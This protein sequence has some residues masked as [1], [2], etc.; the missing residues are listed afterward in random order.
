MFNYINK[1][2]RRMKKGFFL[3]LFFFLAFPFLADAFNFAGNITGPAKLVLNQVEAF[4]GPIAS[5]FALVIIF[6]ILS[7][8]AFYVT[9]ILLQGAIENSNEALNIIHG[10]A[11]FV[12]QAGWNF[13]SG[14][15]NMI[16]LIAFIVIAIAI[17]LGSDSYG[18]KKSLPRLIIVAFLTN[19]TLL[20]VSMAVD[21]TNAI[22]NTVAGDFDQEGG[23]FLIEGITPL[24]NVIPTTIGILLGSFTARLIGALVPLGGIVANTALVLSFTALLPFLLQGAILG[25]ILLLLAGT[26]FLFYAV[27]TARTLVISILAILSPFAL[28]CYIFPGTKKYFDMWVQ[29]FIQWLLVGVALVFFLYIA[30]AMAPLAIRVG[31]DTIPLPSWMSWWT[32]ELVSYI[33]LLIYFIVVLGFTKKFVPALANSMID[34]AKGAAKVVAPYAQMTG[35]SLIKH[36][37]K[38]I[39][40]HASQRMQDNAFRERM[41]NDLFTPADPNAGYLSRIARN[42]RRARAKIYTEAPR[43]DAEETVKE[44]EE[45]FEDRTPADVRDA[46]TSENAQNEPEEVLGAIKYARKNKINIRRSL[47]SLSADEYNNVRR[48]ASLT[49]DDKDLDRMMPGHA[50]ERINNEAD[51]PAAAQRNI[52]SFVSGLSKDDAKNIG[53]SFASTL[54]DTNARHHEEIVSLFRTL[55]RGSKAQRRALAEGGQRTL[56]NNMIHCEATDENGNRVFSQNEMSSFFSSLIGEVGHLFLNEREVAAGEAELNRQNQQQNNQQNN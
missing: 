1:I 33:V 5:F 14:I 29:H 44:A 9:A 18:L 49:E 31:Q 37:K 54:G 7:A 17:I 48:I 26:F 12:I 13:T 20:F 32:G 25:I 50:I 3:C 45:S 55:I 19:F 35:T 30:I 51:S 53:K 21:F 23:N 4:T 42:A 41:A 52:Q 43:L 8:A 46:I 38:G 36:Q 34:G 11:A 27:F 6:L 56:I 40:Q 24:V 39:A 15:V 2:N 22:Y 28:F 47:D 16:L 10:D